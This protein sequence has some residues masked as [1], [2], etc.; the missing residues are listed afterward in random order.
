MEW[1]IV[2]VAGFAVVTGLVIVLARG[3][4]ARWERDRRSARV[5]APA[6][7]PTWRQ[8][9]AARLHAGLARRVPRVHLPHGR[10]RPHLPHGR[11]ALHLP[12][13]PH[14]PHKRVA[15]HLPRPA[16]RVPHLVVRRPHLPHG[17][18]LPGRRSARVRPGRSGHRT[19]MLEEPDQDEQQ[20]AAQQEHSS[21]QGTGTT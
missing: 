6:P 15:L 8:L 18:H 12:H 14:L 21:A 2:S 1:G 11:V 17:L 5:A 4:T 20:A 16:L 19:G 3:N 10:M 7:Q 9:A 13:L